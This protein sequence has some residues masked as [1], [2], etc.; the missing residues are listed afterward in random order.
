MIL[1]SSREML[2]VDE[3]EDDSPKEE[4]RAV[5]LVSWESE[6]RKSRSSCQSASEKYRIPAE[7]QTT[8]I[9]PI[10]YV[11][12]DAGSQTRSGHRLSVA[13]T[14]FRSL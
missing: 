5:G 12:N 9:V 8:C 7:Q 6:M 1:S 11:E 13:P 2:A 4:T 10:V 3:R 14:G